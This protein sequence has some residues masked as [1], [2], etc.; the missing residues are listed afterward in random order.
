MVFPS[1]SED[2]KQASRKG[3]A[4]LQLS[5]RT[6]AVLLRLCAPAWRSGGDWPASLLR[7]LQS[8]Q[9]LKVGQVAG[10]EARQVWAL[11]QQARLRSGGAI[12]GGVSGGTANQVCR[13]V[14]L[15]AAPLSGGARSLSTPSSS[16][17]DAVV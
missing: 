13:V 17:S 4:L 9:V 2:L 8:R 5:S 16:L 7:V 10:A 15:N 11:A 1:S 12:D 14:S 3:I 6:V